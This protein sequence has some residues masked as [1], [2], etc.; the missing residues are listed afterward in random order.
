[1]AK[2]PFRYIATYLLVNDYEPLGSCNKQGVTIIMESDKDR[3]FNKAKE[4]RNSTPLRKSKSLN[5][6]EVVSVIERLYDEMVTVYDL[7]LDRETLVTK[8]V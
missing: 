3:K 8:D 4:L 6:P 1:M 7:T 2:P 5:Y